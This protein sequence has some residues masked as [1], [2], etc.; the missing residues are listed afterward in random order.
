MEFSSDMKLELYYFIMKREELSSAFDMANINNNAMQ[1]SSTENNSKQLKCML[2]WIWG[3][4]IKFYV[5]S[6]I[7]RRITFCKKI[8]VKK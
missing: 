7:L 8:V 6:W 2:S 4:H 1:R 3:F 5:P